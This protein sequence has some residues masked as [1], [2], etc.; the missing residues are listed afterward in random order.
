MSKQPHH[1]P[2]QARAIEAAQHDKATLG[3]PPKPKG[4]PIY[5]T[6]GHSAPDASGPSPLDPTAQGKHEPPVMVHPGM[7][8]QQ[9]AGATFNGEDVLK[10][11]LQSGGRHGLPK[12]KG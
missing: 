10:E 12:Q 9:I 3:K 1:G 5:L 6:H 4:Y 2:A 7:T 8:R 11:A